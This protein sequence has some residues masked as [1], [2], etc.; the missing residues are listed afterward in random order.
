MNN[1]KKIAVLLAALMAVSM[2]ACGNSGNNEEETKTTTT[3]AAIEESEVTEESEAED[4]SKAEDAPAED[5]TDVTAAEDIQFD[6]ASFT[7]DELKT[8]KLT[9]VASFSATAI[10]SIRPRMRSISPATATR[11]KS[12]ATAMLCR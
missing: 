6:A 12:W 3:A 2:T 5:S 10:S 8:A 7:K 1:S 9:E 4:E 11:A